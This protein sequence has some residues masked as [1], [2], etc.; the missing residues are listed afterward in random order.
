MKCDAK[1]NIW[2][3]APGGIWIYAPSGFLLGKVK[4]PENTAN[5]HWGGSDWR[6]LYVCATSSVYEI[7][8]KVGP[9][10][11]PFMRN[12]SSQVTPAIT[13][14]ATLEFDPGKAALIIQDM[15]NDVVI[16]GGAFAESGA[17]AHCAEQNTIANI[18]SLASACRSRGIPVIHVWFVVDPGCPGLTMNAP[19]FRGVLDENALLRG[20]W[21]AAPVQGLEPEAGDFIVEKSRMSPWDTSRLETILR[22]RGVTTLINT[23]AW[24]NMSVEHTARTGADKGYIVISPEDACSTM[25]AEWHRAS[26]EYATQNVAQV[27]D[28]QSVLRKLGVTGI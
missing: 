28:T 17:P 13:K 26:M 14:T 21:G 6:T 2:V 19:L 25:N 18:A 3:T 24:T 1:G 23:G 4:V 16:E 9:H 12:A 11:E 5:F 7:P 20:S 27:T 8:V 15:Q 22:A 10:V